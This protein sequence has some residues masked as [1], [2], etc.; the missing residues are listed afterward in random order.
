MI[1]PDSP[2]LTSLGKNLMYFKFLKNCAKKFKEIRKGVL[3]ESEVIMARNLKTVSLMS[4]VP[5]KEL[6]MNSLLL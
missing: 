5:Q 3:S 4:Y 1:F 6:V 2:G